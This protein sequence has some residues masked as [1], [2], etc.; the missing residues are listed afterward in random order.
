LKNKFCNF[1]VLLLA[2]SSTSFNLD[3]TPNPDQ[4]A[5]MVNSDQ[6]MKTPSLF[7]LQAHWDQDTHVNK[8]FFT[9]IGTI[10]R[11]Y[12]SDYYET[13]QCG[14][15]ETP[16]KF[17]G[18]NKLG[19]FTLVHRNVVHMLD[20]EDPTRIP[21]TIMFRLSRPPRSYSNNHLWPLH[22][23]PN[24]VLG[25]QEPPFQVA[26]AATGT[27]LVS[28]HYDEDLGWVSV[29]A[30]T[31]GQ[32]VFITFT[33]PLSEMQLTFAAYTRFRADQ[34]PV[35][36]NA[37]IDH[38]PIRIADRDMFDTHRQVELG[39][40]V[41]H[42]LALGIEAHVTHPATMDMEAERPTTSQEFHE[43]WYRFTA[44]IS[45]NAEQL[46]FATSSGSMDI[47]VPAL[48]CI[49]FIDESPPEHRATMAV[50]LDY[51]FLM[52]P[53]ALTNFIECCHRRNL[54]IPPPEKAL[55]T[56]GGH[57]ID[58]V[59][60]KKVHHPDPNL[61]ACYD[62][63]ANQPNMQQI[64]TALYKSRPVTKGKTLLTAAKYRKA[65]ATGRSTSSMLE[66][67]V[68]NF[69]AW[70][71]HLIGVEHEKGEVSKWLPLTASGAPS[72]VA[73]PNAPQVP[74]TR[75]SSPTPASGTPKYTMEDIISLLKMLRPADS[76]ASS[77]AATD[78]ASEG[79]SKAAAPSP[80]PPAHS[81]SK[82]QGRQPST[83]S[84]RS[85]SPSPR[86]TSPFEFRSRPISTGTRRK[87]G[88]RSH[89]TSPHPHRQR[90]D[91]Q[92]EPGMYNASTNVYKWVNP[93]L[94]KKR[95][96]SRPSRLD[97]H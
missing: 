40:R 35:P 44:M 23:Q 51:I 52:T 12:I 81:R 49:R 31:Y 10:E 88:D 15:A 66:P 1:L 63:S 50:L 94:V 74:S 87:S 36:H 25:L 72:P 56:Y 2:F 93:N 89:S 91:Q 82:S 19:K 57:L 14:H 48:N 90:F 22:L 68:G 37:I 95:S 46:R 34:P 42:K 58:C 45:R 21:M 7:A 24:P 92:S 61:P 28:T 79:T 9:Q 32:P 86:S 77:S 70:Q 20:F 75:A 53:E 71:H 39:Q 30:N 29:L 55:V 18:L 17:I 11:H 59:Q 27:E 8:T 62:H 26:S 4:L 97:L 64:L 54:L 60:N 38:I 84:G 47:R 67:V 76:A 16:L 6:P 65:I 69:N 96:A 85:T 73:H 41:H 43:K 13:V 83:D 5:T 33:A 80:Q 3:Q 78:T